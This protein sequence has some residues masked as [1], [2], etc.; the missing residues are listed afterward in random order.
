[1]SLIECCEASFPSRIRTRGKD[2]YRAGRIFPVGNTNDRNLIAEV[3]GSA[4]QVYDVC[5][6]FSEV[7]S[8]ELY[9]VCTCPYAVENSTCKHLWAT[10]LACDEHLLQW[11]F[12][13]VF[14]MD[15]YYYPE[16]LKEIAQFRRTR[17]RRDSKTAAPDRLAAPKRNG[18]LR[19]LTSDNQTSPPSDLA[20]QQRDEAELQTMVKMLWMADHGH[21]KLSAQD[22]T[23]LEDTLAYHLAPVDT[24]RRSPAKAVKPKS[25]AEMFELHKPKAESKSFFD[26]ADRAKDASAENGLIKRRE[27]HCWFVIL[28]GPSQMQGELVV[29][30]C[31]RVVD[32]Q[33]NGFYKPIEYASELELANYDN[34]VDRE[35]LSLLLGG[36]LTALAREDSFDRLL[37]N[38][39]IVRPEIYSVLLPKLVQPERCGWMLDASP[40]LSEANPV[41]WLEP[42]SWSFRIRIKEDRRAKKWTMKGELE[43]HGEFIA[44][45]DAVLL[46]DSGLM[47]YD[48]ELS[49]VELNGAE[50]WLDLWRAHPELVASFKEQEAVS[51]FLMSHSSSALIDLP[52]RL[53]Y[54]HIDADPVPLL[55]FLDKGLSMFD[56]WPVLL[57][58]EY[59]GIQISAVE[60]VGGCFDEEGNRYLRRSEEAEMAALQQLVDHD[61]R[62]AHLSEQ[63]RIDLIMPEVDF[64]KRL[65]S[66]FD[67]GWAFERDGKRFHPSG[68]LSV[69]VKSGV[70]W[71]DV[72][73]VARFGNLEVGLPE[74][75]RAVRQHKATIRL[76]NGEE[77]LL[78]EEWQNQLQRL[79]QLGE[80]S[81]EGLKF[82]PSQALLIDSLLSSSPAS[83]DYDL[84]FKRLR[85]RLKSFRGVKPVNPPRDFQGS[86]REYQQVGLGWLKFLQE[87]GLGGCLAD[88][89]GLGKTVQILSFLLLRR[90]RRLT[91]GEQRRPTLIVVPKSLVFNWIQ[92]AKRF[93]PRLQFIDYTG[94]ERSD[95]IAHGEAADVWITTYAT[96]RLDIETLATV[97]FD[98]VILDEAQA[99]K[100]ASSQT[101]RAARALQAEHRLALTGTPV[102]NHLGELW[103]IFE[104]INPGMLG[105]AS[106]FKELTQSADDSQ[107]DLTALREAIAPFLLRRTKSEVLTDLPEKSEQVILCDLSDRE[108]RAYNELRDHYRAGLN[109][110][111]RKSGLKRAK[112]QVLE[113]LLRLRQAACHPGLLD[114]KRRKQ[115]SAKIDTLLIQL[116]ELRAEGH[117]VLVFSQFTTLL[118][119]VADKLNKKRWDFEYLDGQTKDRQEAVERFQSSRGCGIFLISLKAG[120][121][122]L[123]LTAAD[124]VFLLDP[125]WNPAVES[126]AIDRAHRMGQTNPVFAYRLIARGT[127]EEKIL[128]MQASKRELA[129]SIVSANESLL[130]QL[131]AD[132]LE[133]LLS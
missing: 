124:Y 123:N 30:I 17:D 12:E 62:R 93:A 24:P 49:I 39:V 101:A 51:Q 61:F 56:G 79:L 21:I 43:R 38:E 118:K 28:V 44:L 82:K 7:E 23:E 111:I 36:G 107:R 88:D 29:Q 47:L 10:L 102:E 1:M 40:P 53:R 105:T 110:K 112:I 5:I 104:F 74:L 116:E 85:K 66:L 91:K 81:E 113:A 31:Q 3:S 60:E 6:D 13:D 108:R 99:I 37:S 64:D 122:G 83:V 67:K 59:E 75:L 72:E 20:R 27:V 26:G 127:V 125:W 25:F 73:G 128:E 70:D 117:R 45:Q 98:Y 32:E 22:R 92:E 9:V 94:P 54:Q 14:D 46:L 131:T 80:E 15:V 97:P 96:M 132:D 65:R 4:G 89:M 126:Q 16:L 34:E 2:Y 115:G 77:G 8:G 71:F 95:R 42:N 120:G 90:Q 58:F 57:A 35:S 69:S 106:T 50:A 18:K 33:S 109:E 55:K 119:I 103:S 11:P 48:D 129:E 78:P 133:Q 130:R 87:F 19:D 68:S 84:K 121:H 100:N 63:D 114:P 86:L 41:K 52:E 76:E